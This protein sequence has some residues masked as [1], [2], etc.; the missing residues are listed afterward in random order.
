MVTYLQLYVCETS[1][2]IIGVILIHFKVKTHEIRHSINS[3][4]DKSDVIGKR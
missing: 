3:E 4:F 2:L 1:L